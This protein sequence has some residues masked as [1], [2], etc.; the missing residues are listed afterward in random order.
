MASHFVRWAYVQTPARL[1]RLP[2]KLLEDSVNLNEK[3]RV[4]FLAARW[5]LAELM[6]RVY[7]MQQLPALITMS[8]GRPCFAD[9][10][11]PDFSIAYAGN[12]VGVLLAEEGGRAGLDMEIVRAHSRQTVENQLQCLSSG[13][14]AWINAQQDPVEA[15]TQLWTL[16]QSVLKLTGESQHDA[17]A[18]RL[19]PAS[20]RLRS[21]AFPDIQALS[22][23]EPLMV[24]SCAL[25]PGTQRLRLWELDQENNWHA[26][27]DV[28]VSKPNIGP[29]ALRLTSMPQ[30]RQ[31]Q[32][33]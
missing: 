33:H 17:D 26:L 9:A 11:L 18:L 1:S 5:L 21:A 2:Q 10:D 23:V 25:S 15:A 31:V 4:R 28:E 27:R 24:W 7:G 32:Q 13:E 22:D 20:G 29:R 12:Q 16:R 19:H 3:R 14:K 8:S 6:L 30:E